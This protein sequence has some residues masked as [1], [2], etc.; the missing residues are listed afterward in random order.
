MAVQAAERVKGYARDGRK[1]VENPPALSSVVR[2]TPHGEWH[3]LIGLRNV[4]S[5]GYA[6]IDMGVVWAI[7]DTY[8]DLLVEEL[9]E[10]LT[11]S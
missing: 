3:R 5:H 9:N 11:V 2:G 4:I 1:P 10:I 6:E 8:L 7:I